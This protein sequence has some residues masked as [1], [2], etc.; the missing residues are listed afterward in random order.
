MLPQEHYFENI[1]FRMK[2]GCSFDEAKI[3]ESNTKYLTKEEIEA[4]QTCVLYVINDLCDWD[5][6]KLKLILDL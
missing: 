5:I 3:D 6:E 4:I 1:L 2:R